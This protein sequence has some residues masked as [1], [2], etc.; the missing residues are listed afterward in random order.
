M[1]L[2]AFYI[3][4]LRVA[5]VCNEVLFFLMIYIYIKYQE[6]QGNMPIQMFFRGSDALSDL[7]NLLGFPW[8]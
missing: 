3:T 4:K 2:R 8:V 5:Y 6:P 7:S 1:L